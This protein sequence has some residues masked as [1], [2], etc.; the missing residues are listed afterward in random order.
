[1]THSMKNI[2]HPSLMKRA[3]SCTSTRRSSSLEM[4]TLL[5]ITK[6][7]FCIIAIDI[8]LRS[9]TRFLML[10]A[11]NFEREVPSV[12]VQESQ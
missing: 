2:E 3:K 10:T 11:L 5:V 1:M 4:T 7:P 9:W 12:P 6:P 8:V